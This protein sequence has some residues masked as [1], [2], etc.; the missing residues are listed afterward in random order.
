M[1]GTVIRRRKRKLKSEINVVPYIDVMLVLLIIFMV[2]APLL[3]LGIDVD[4]P[5]SNAKSIE[6]KNDPVVVQIDDKGNFFLAV[7]AGSNE[8][9][10]KE[11]LATK[12]G[13]LVKQNGKE[14]LQVYIAGDGRS[15]YQPVMDAMNIL[16][17]AGVEKVGLMSQPEKGA[18]K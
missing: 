14:K 12:V 2:T 7:K 16:K 6:T 9:V 5:K 11:T 10:S 1:S 17:D 4:L 13:A 18:K 8:A 15:N 3:T